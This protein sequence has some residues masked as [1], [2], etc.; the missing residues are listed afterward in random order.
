MVPPSHISYD[1][2]F[3]NTM[4]MNFIRK[5]PIPRDVKQEYPVPENLREVRKANIRQI[6]NVLSG[7]S[8]K[9]LIFIGP[10]SADREDSVIDYLGRLRNMLADGDAEGMKAMMRKSTVRRIALDEGR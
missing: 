5:L 10:C 1:N 6:E 2:P 4:N 8:D 7:A 3:E 9:F